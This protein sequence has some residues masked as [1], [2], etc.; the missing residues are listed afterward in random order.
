MYQ[1]ISTTSC[2]ELEC[3]NNLEGSGTGKTGR[4]GRPSCL[5]PSRL[6]NTTKSASLFDIETGEI[7]VQH[8]PMLK[9]QLQS[10]ARLA[11]PQHR[12]HTCMRY[13][14]SD[15]R[16][17]QVRQSQ[18]SG[19]AY[20]SGLM[21]CGSVWTCPICAPKIQA[22]RAQ[23]VRAAID[24]WSGS[25]VLITQ[26]VPHKVRDALEPLLGAFTLALRKFKGCKGYTRAQVLYGISGSIRA[27]EITD[28][29]NGWH[30]HAH[31]ILFLDVPEVNL[32][33]FRATLFPLWESATRRAG[34][35]CLSL[36]AFDVQDARAV[37]QYV[38]KLGTEYERGP[39]HELTRAHSKRGRGCSLTPFDMLRRYLEAP[40]DGRFLAR[41][42]E[43]A[44]CFHGKRQLVW[45]DGL[46][47]RL[48]GSDGPTDQQISES[49][50][51]VD[52]V[53]AT[54]SFQQWKSIRRNNIQGYVLQVVQEFGDSVLSHLLNSY[55]ST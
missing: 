28:G 50:G 29:S 47:K 19:N 34:F 11:L 54:I 5:S 51:E 52:P 22:V 4:R 35:A 18:K 15:R 23:E 43:F 6:D 2:A 7:I 48:L 49:L 37:R 42:A 41:F 20:F 38:T 26:T 1:N 13:L 21:S 36:K 32:D 53:L 16:E 55:D 25:V 3:R 24:A 8:D 17:V 45:S 9:W 14:R 39:E 33:D 46:K 44:Y 12:I 27:L 30:P 10:V 31:T 40:D